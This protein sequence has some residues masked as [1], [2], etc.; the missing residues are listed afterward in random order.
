M[1]VGEN[2]RK[3]ILEAKVGDCDNGVIDKQTRSAQVS[4]TGATVNLTDIGRRYHDLE[5]GD[6]LEV[7]VHEDGFLVVPR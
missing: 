3:S 7:I 4:T 2:V 1:A 6:E 5:Q